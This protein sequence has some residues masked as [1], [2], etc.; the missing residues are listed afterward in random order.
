MQKVT[1]LVDNQA[2]KGL[3]A[4]HGLSLWIETEDER[5]LF[6]TGQGGVFANNAQMLGIDLGQTDM[7]VLS[8]GHYDHTGGIPQIL[9]QARNINVYRHP[10]NQIN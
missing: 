6:D 1:I 2:G 4:E 10:T 5:I 9:Q 8:H 3:I 7:L